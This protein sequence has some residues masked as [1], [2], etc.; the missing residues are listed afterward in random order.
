MMRNAETVLNVIRERGERGLPLENIYRLL[1]N[2]NLYLRAYGRLY[3]NQG[4]MTKGTTAE[5]VDGMS[6]AKIDRIIEELRYERFRWTPVRR[7]NIP[8]PNGKTRALGLPTWTD[9]LLQEVIRMILEAYYEPQF[10]DRSHGF[11]PDRGCHTALSNVVS[12]WHGVRWFIEGDIKGCFDNINHEVMLFVLGE[13]LHDNRFLRLLKYLLKAGYMEDWKYG[14]TLSGTPQGGVVSPVL[15]NVYLDRLDKF[16]ETML[17]PTYTRGTA[18]KPNPE[19]RALRSRRQYHQGV[20]HHQL[21][22]Q[23]RKQMQQLPTGDPYDAGYRRLR[24]VRYADDF[25]LGFI[26]PKAEAEQMKE[27]LATFLRDSLK[28]ELSKEKTLITHATSQAAKFLGYELANQQANDQRDHTGKRHIN[29]GIGLRVPAKVIEQHCRAYMRNGKPTHRAE[30]MN[31]DD[32]TIV[33]RYQSEFRGVVQYYLLAQNVAHF[34]KLQRV[35][36]E[37]LAK[38]LANKHKTSCRNVLRRYLSTADTEHGQRACLKVVVQRGEGKRPLTAQFG[39]IPLKRKR[40]AVL[41]DQQPQRYRPDR[42][43]LI[44]RLVADECELCGSTDDI[45]VHHVRALRDLNVIGRS[46]KPPWVQ[47]M[48]ARKRKTLVVCRTCHTDIHYGRSNPQTQT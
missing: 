28:L 18:R 3:S 34:G 41:V 1:Y 38:T 39:G 20:G 7:V 14:R 4:A 9:K 13:K 30:L 16:V 47:I 46:Q 40:Q 17:I 2:R 35:T 19:W 21:A 24:Y 10:S 37:S 29:G 12:Y 11:R 43:E 23:L 48:A 31:D 8:K 5:T 33:S 32:Y 27:S 45:H 22:V 42:V 36:Q 25:V 6:L 44:Q 15:A 26:G